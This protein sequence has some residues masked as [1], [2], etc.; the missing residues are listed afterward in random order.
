MTIMVIKLT[1]ATPKFKSY[2]G[3]T[4]HGKGYLIGV[5]C[6]MPKGL[7][8]KAIYL[9][10]KRSEKMAEKRM[11][12]K[13]VMDSDNFLEMP[14][15]AQLLYVH[16]AL[17]A[18]DEGFIDK[19]KSIMRMVG[20]KDDDIKLLIAKQYLIAF[21][22]GVVVV[23]HWKMH[24]TIRND[25]YKPTIHQ[26]EISQLTCDGQGIY[27]LTAKCLP[28]DNQTATKRQPSDNQVTT[29]CLPTDSTCETQ[30]RLD[31]NRLDKNRLEDRVQQSAS[32]SF[33]LQH[34]VYLFNTICVSF[35]KVQTINDKRKRQLSSIIKQ[36]NPD[37]ESVFKRIE[38]SDFLTGR[39]GKWKNCNFDWI[40][41]PTNFVK[42]IEGNYD[43][44][45]KGVNTDG[46]I[47]INA[48]ITI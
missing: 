26:E 37:F 25:R 24:N 41:N 42:I 34:I 31:K 35:K 48:G 19:A 3:D 21:D 22:S 44:D 33:Q 23:R 20:A 2:I 46:E 1:S 16:L 29:D 5:L 32:S 6:P 39:N 7:N 36:F 10:T 43:N 30:N 28:I 47:V 40:I 15:T 12:S 4:R 45:D 13:C 17:R 9:K 18:D 8:L 11:F 14:A 27:Q 38:N